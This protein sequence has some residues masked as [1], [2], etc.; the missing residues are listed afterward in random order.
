MDRYIG[1]DVHSASCTVGV[2]SAKGKRLSSTVLETNGKALVAFLRTIPGTRH[3]IIEEGTQAAWLYEILSPHVHEMVVI[4]VPKSKG[5]KN[6]K[7]DA[8]G[9]AEKLR[10]GSIERRVFKGL[11]EFSTL[12]SMGKAYRTVM[13]DSV[14]VMNRLKGVFRSRGISTAGRRVFGQNTKEEWVKKL[15]SKIQPLASTYYTQL[16]VLLPVRRQALKDLLKE[17]RKH[18]LF[19]ILKTIPGLGPIRV[20]EMLPIVVTPYRFPSKANF[21]TYC[22]LGVVMRSSSDWVRAAD[23]SWLRTNKEQTRGLNLNHNRTLKKIFKGAATT[24]VGQKRREE[25]IFQHYLSLLDNGTNPNLA[26]LTIARQIASVTLALW[27]SGEEY[28]G[29]KMKKQ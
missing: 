23:G 13:I 6:D 8:F 25:P 5:Q 27:R 9:L 19:H 7:L 24:V 14:R 29:K 11:G 21:W 26:K 1:M 28:D 20:A 18:H 2:L 22:G 17:A 3:L 12:S 15:P 10:T 16:D 4:S